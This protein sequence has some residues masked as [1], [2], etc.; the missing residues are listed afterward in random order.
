M[1]SLTKYKGKPDSKGH[2]PTLYKVQFVGLDRVRRTVYL[3]EVAAR[4]ARNV[5]AHVGAIVSSL[6][7]GQHPPDETARWL[8]RVSDVLHEKLAAVGLVRARACATLKAFLD[9]YTRKRGDVKTATST[10]WG[11]TKRN[12]LAYF[13][14]DRLLRSITEGDAEDWRRWLFTSEKLAENTI[15][16]RCQ[17][18]KQ[19]FAY[20]RRHRLIETNPFEVLKGATKGNPKRFYFVTADESTKVL[21]A[22]P[23]TQWKLIF[24]LC[25]FGGLRCPSELAPLKWGDVDWENDRITVRSPKTEHHTGGESRVI[26][27]FPELR[28]YLEAALNELLEDFDPQAKRLSQQ[29]VVSRHLDS[30]TN[31]RT[32]FEKIIKR[33]GLTP[34]PKL[35]QNLR[36]SRQTELEEKFPSHVV[37]SWIGNSVQVA[38]KH[39]LQTTDEHFERAAKTTH[40]TTHGIAEIGGIERNK[41]VEEDKKTQENQRFP[42]FVRSG[43]VGVTGLEPVTSAMST[44]R[45]NQLS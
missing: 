16:K 40:K 4:D 22:C 34:W 30:N 43:S 36:S 9:D 24:A 35:F 20:A 7:A 33:A 42:G 1:A 17:N 39:Y 3:G 26:P 19:F 12:L 32:T 45:S 44:R 38:K 18:A 14:E 41:E 31:L 29:A 10:N 37:C 21:N 11:H 5:K 13:G 8:S 6:N 2:S 27:L 28:P 23:D 25:R 15:N